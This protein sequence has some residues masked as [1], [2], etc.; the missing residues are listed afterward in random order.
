MLSSLTSSLEDLTANV[1]REWAESLLAGVRD[2]GEIGELSSFCVRR[3][4]A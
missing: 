4:Y 3:F 1:E 2:E